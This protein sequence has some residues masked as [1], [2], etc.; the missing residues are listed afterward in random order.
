MAHQWRACTAL[1]E[2]QVLNTLN[3]SGIS[4]TTGM[5]WEWWHTPLIPALRRQRQ[6][7]FWVRGQPGLQSELQDSQGY[8]EKPCLKKQNKTKQNKTTGMCT[9]RP[10]LPPPYRHAHAHVNTI[11]NEKES[12]KRKSGLTRSSLWV[13]SAILS[14]DAKEPSINK[15]QRTQD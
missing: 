8:T 3:M 12:Q 10:I 13:L 9:Y 2:G 15:S 11:K 7:D 4:K 14:T 1:A 6:A 5:S